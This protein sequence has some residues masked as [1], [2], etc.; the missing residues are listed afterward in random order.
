MTGNTPSIR[1][2]F[3]IFF[4]LLV[5]SFF[6]HSCKSPTIEDDKNTPFLNYKVKNIDFDLGDEEKFEFSVIDFYS[7]GKGRLLVQYEKKILGEQKSLGKFIKL[8]EDRGKSFAEENEL[9][10]ILGI[11][12]EAVSY[13]FHFIENDIIALAWGKKNLFYI[14]SKDGLRDWS[15]PVQIND[16]QGVVIS[17]KPKLV[18]ENKNDAYL[19][20]LDRRRETTLL[21][22]SASHDGGNTWSAN[23]AIAHDFRESNQSNPQFILGEN[24]RLLVFW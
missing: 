15:D 10:K 2:F 17:R 7:N 21:F 8:S 9:T 14:H 16:E 6:G 5:C 20:W 4:L 1:N 18:Q 12:K 13:N 3:T 23:R 24:N 11:E 22:F 19:V